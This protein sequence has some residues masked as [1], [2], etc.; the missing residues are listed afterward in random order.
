MKRTHE[1]R[2]K[3]CVG[4]VWRLFQW[5]WCEKCKQEFRREFGW[6]VGWWFK[7]LRG[8]PVERFVCTVCCPTRDDAYAW[9]KRP[10]KATPPQ[11]GS[12]LSKPPPTP[13]PSAGVDRTGSF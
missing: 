7:G 10:K 9:F 6:G 12:G 1:D 13:V 4:Q 2:E 5:L 3:A 11:G 8:R